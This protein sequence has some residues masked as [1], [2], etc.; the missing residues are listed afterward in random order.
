MNRQLTVSATSSKCSP[1]QQ[2]CVPLDR[3]TQSPS[4]PDPIQHSNSV[5]L[6]SL[7]DSVLIEQTLMDLALAEFAVRERR[8]SQL[9]GHWRVIVF[10]QLQYN[11]YNINFTI[12]SVRFSRFQYIDNVIQSSPLSSFR[13]FHCTEKF[14]TILDIFIT[15]K[16]SPLFINSHS[17]FP[18]PLAPGN[19]LIYFLSL[20]I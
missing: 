5:T 7:T 10:L 18:L 4:Q 9:H 2:K 15:S 20:Q 13:H 16:R 8:E 19:L 3:R 11:L 14:W 6:S 17:S 12:L 1:D